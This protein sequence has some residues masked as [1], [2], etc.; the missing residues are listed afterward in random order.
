MAKFVRIGDV[1]AIPSH[2]EV[3]TVERSHS[4]VQSITTWIIRHDMMQNVRIN[5]FGDGVV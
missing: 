4:K 5:H 3:T 1:T 2:Q